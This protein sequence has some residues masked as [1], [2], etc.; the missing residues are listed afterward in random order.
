MFQENMECVSR[1]YDALNRR[2]KQALLEEVDPEVEGIVYF[3]ESEGT[4]YRRHS[5]VE[6]M[7][8]EVFSVFPNWHAEVGMTE[9]GDA[10]LAEVRMSATGSSSGRPVAQTGWQV[11]GF[12]AGKVIGFHGYGSRA[13]ALEAGGVRHGPT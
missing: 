12:R 13:D 10:L 6:R 3:M 2:D 8:D 1:M 4:V 11:L 9:F 5:G 7:F